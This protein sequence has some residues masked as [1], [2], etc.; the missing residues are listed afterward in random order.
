[1]AIWFTVGLVD[2]VRLYVPFMMP[3][4]VVAAKFAATYILSSEPE[5]AR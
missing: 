2:E 1:L 4:S 5:Q 3:L